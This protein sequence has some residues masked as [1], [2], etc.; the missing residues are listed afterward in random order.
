MGKGDERA[1][2]WR[3]NLALHKILGQLD[4]IDAK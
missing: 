3:R 1:G 2:G 4:K